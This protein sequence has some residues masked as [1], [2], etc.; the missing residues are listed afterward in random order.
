MQ[1]QGY[2]PIHSYIIG[3]FNF[4]NINSNSKFEFL[5][6]GFRF[7]TICWCCCELHLKMITKP[8]PLFSFG[9]HIEL[10]ASTH[11]LSIKLMHF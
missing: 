4:I 8:I 5:I 10:M 11:M 3:P 1:G 9:G 2:S 7:L 6:K